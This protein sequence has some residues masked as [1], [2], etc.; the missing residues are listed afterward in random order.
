MNEPHDMSTALV[1]KND[2]AA[3][4]GIRASGAKQ[5]ILAPGNG[6]TGGHSWLQASQGDEPSG[7]YLYKIRD[8]INNTA[9]DI[10]E[11]LDYDFSGQHVVC[12]QSFPLNMAPLTAWLKTYQLKAMVTEFGGDNNTMC[13]KY[14][15]DAVN[16]MAANPECKSPRAIPTRSKSLLTCLI[17]IGWTA[18]AAGPIWGT[19]SPCCTDYMPY[20]SLEPG[21]RAGD[22][23]PGLYYSVWLKVLQKLVPKGLQKAGISS[24]HGPR[25]RN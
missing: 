4:N 9:I 20:G 7:D 1:L 17:D 13:D 23:S 6:Y 14:L 8:P 18:W 2:Q 10:H 16:Y 22:G 3:I 25:G 21:S 11:Y 19:S 12:N 15:T 5:L 24:I